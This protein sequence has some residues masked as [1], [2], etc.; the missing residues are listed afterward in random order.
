MNVVYDS[1]ITA[2]GNQRKNIYLKVNTTRDMWMKAKLQ[3]LM[4]FRKDKNSNR[5]PTWPEM[6]VVDEFHGATN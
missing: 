2:R 3:A 4:D 5:R 1:P 6:P